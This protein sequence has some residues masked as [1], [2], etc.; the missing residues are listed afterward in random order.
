MHVS[1]DLKYAQQRAKST[2]SSQSVVF[3]PSTDS[4][5]LPEATD[6]DHPGAPYI[7]DLTETSYSASLVSASFG[8]SG[9]NVVFDMYGRPDNSGTVVLSVGAQQRTINVDASGNVSVLP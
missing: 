3:T 7:V 5:T 8:A 1:A 2:S 4:Y 9:G 6:M